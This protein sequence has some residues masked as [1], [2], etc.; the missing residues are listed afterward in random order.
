[1]PAYDSLLTDWTTTG[2][3]LIPLYSELLLPQLLI[4]DCLHSHLTRVSCYT[5]FRYPR[6]FWLTTRISGKVVSVSESPF[7]QQWVYMSLFVTILYYLCVG[8]WW[9]S[10]KERDHWEDQDVCGCTILKWILER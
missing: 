4:Y 9:E 5:A 3:F 7:C 8:Y 1:M 6:K 2:S 10:Q